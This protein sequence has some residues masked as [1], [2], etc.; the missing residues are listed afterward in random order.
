[1][2]VTTLPFEMGPT[3]DSGPIS[4]FRQHFK[5]ESAKPDYQSPVKSAAGPS[6]VVP[7]VVNG[8]GLGLQFYLD[9][10]TGR[11]VIRVLDV[12]SGK[13]V[14]QIPS[15]DVLNFLRELE[16]RQGPVISLKL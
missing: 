15:E 7:P 12:E 3:G 1:M 5:A 6:Q 10:E 13:V 8:L 2:K 16:K 14:R 9:K 4:K 11:S